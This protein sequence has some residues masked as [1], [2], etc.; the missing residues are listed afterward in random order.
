MTFFIFAIFEHFQILQFSEEF[1]P[2]IPVIMTSEFGK[3]LA[4]FKAPNISNITDPTEWSKDSEVEPLK[5]GPNPPPIFTK[6]DKALDIKNAPKSSGKRSE[7]LCHGLNL[8]V[9]TNVADD[10][11]DAAFDALYKTQNESQCESQ[12]ELRNDS[13]H[14]HNAN[15]RGMKRTH[16]DLMEIS[17]DNDTENMM[18]NESSISSISTSKRRKLNDGT[19]IT[20]ELDSFRSLQRTNNM[21][22]EEEKRK[23]DSLWR[24]L[25]D[26]VYDLHER[27]RSNDGLKHMIRT[28]LADAVQSR[29]MTEYEKLHEVAVKHS[30]EHCCIWLRIRSSLARYVHQLWIYDFDCDF[31]FKG[32]IIQ[33]AYFKVL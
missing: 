4:L 19:A 1:T 8:S 10:A 18:K 5:L 11:S 31:T 12:S 13:N 26:T 15:G 16:S 6:L 21:M 28:N 14:N 2:K 24:L 30:I 23:K 32:A 27:M 20:V 9:M 3:V 7:T 17:M 22:I 25:S 29:A 33:S